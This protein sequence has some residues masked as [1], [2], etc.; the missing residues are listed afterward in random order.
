MGLDTGASKFR[1]M[2]RGGVVVADFADVAGAQAPLLA[3]DHGGG[4]LAAGQNLGGAEFD[5]GATGGI[6][7]D[8]DESVGGVEADADDVELW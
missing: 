6:V 1:A 5:F 8:G 2:E 3:G 7:G 4:D